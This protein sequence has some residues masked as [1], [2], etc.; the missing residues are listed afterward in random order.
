MNQKERKYTVYEIEKLTKGK[1]SKYKLT[2]AIESNELQAEEVKEKKRGR[3]IPNYFIYES[4][5]NE[6]LKKLEKKKKHYINV[7]EDV[8]EFKNSE[9]KLKHEDKIVSLMEKSFQSISKI[10]KR[11]SQ[12]EEENAIII[13]LLAKQQKANAG[14]TSKSSER[15]ELLEQLSNAVDSTNKDILDKLSNLA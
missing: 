8:I 10:E 12:M 13:P 2:K 14:D 15:K 3:G 6:Y 9:E 1:L 5:L 7:P 11:L 4:A